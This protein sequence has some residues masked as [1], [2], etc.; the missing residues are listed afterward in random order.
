ML[1]TDRLLDVGER[2][3]HLLFD[4]ETIHD[5]FQQDAERLRLELAGRVAEVHFAIEYVVRLPSLEEARRVIAG[6][7]P[8]V[9]HV[10]VLLYFEL[11]DGRVR[12]HAPIH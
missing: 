2:G 11:L 6:L 12:S 3:I 10:L 4:A 7:E 1:D 5:A 8:P 9:R